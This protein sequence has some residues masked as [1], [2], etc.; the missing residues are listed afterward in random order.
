M[1]AAAAL[2][3]VCWHHGKLLDLAA[4][5]GVDTSQTRC[6]DEHLMPDDTAI[7]PDGT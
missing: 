1:P 2:N 5:L 4:E 3:L 6:I 7:P